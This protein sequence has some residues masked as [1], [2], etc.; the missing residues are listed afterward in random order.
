MIFKKDTP[1]PDEEVKKV[2]RSRRKQDLKEIIDL[3][4]DSPLK[5]KGDIVQADGVTSLESL[6]K[7]NTDVKTRIIMQMAKGAATGEVKHAE[8]LMKYSGKEPPKQQ[9]LTMELPTIVDDMTC[10]VTPVVASALVE[11]DEE[12]EEEDE[13]SKDED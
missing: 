12:D 8:F 10:R 3:I 9:H 13:E 4:L 7:C 5:N 11:R 2:M 1:I 6:S